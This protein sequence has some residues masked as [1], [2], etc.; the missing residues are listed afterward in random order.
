MMWKSN[1]K[2]A[3]GKK[4]EVLRKALRGRMCPSRKEVIR[5]LNMERKRKCSRS[6]WDVSWEHDE[7]ISNIVYHVR[8]ECQTNFEK[9]EKG[10]KNESNS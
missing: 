5:K 10:E 6:V 9:I 1:W 4:T 7:N 2:S 3:T 8:K